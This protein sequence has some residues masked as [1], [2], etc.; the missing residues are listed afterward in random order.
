[1]LSHHDQVLL[2]TLANRSLLERIPFSNQ[3][4]HERFTTYLDTATDQRWDVAFPGT[5]AQHETTILT[6]LR[7]MGGG[8][9]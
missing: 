4:R 6:A 5:M 7:T 2:G 9:C 8:P 3:A 1:M